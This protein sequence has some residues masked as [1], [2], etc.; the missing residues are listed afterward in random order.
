MESIL[1][2]TTAD[3]EPR[4]G[5]I[6][7]LPDV[8]VHQHACLAQAITRLAKA[9]G[10]TSMKAKV[11]S[12]SSYAASAEVPSRRGRGRTIKAPSRNV[13][14]LD[15]QELTSAFQD[16]DPGLR[17]QIL[18]LAAADPNLRQQ[19]LQAAH[20]D[21]LEL[22]GLLETVE[23]NPHMRRPTTA[24]VESEDDLPESVDALG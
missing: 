14:E 8:L 18:T 21:P 5:P 22:H 1:R 13:A 6:D 10:H 3:P 11:Q 23:A 4:S 15:L 19:L 24:F 17:E 16:L 20:T 2:Q 12:D 7:V 9:L